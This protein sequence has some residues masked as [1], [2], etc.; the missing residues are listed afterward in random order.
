MLQG[1]QKV[2]KQQADNEQQVALE[3]TP[4]A[5]VLEGRSIWGHFETQSLGNGVSR[6]F[7]EVL[8]FHR[9]HHVVSSEYTQDWPGNNAIKISQVFHDIAWLE[10]FTD[11][12]LFKYVFN[13]I[14][15]WET[16]ALQFYLKVLI[17]LFEVMVESS[18]LRMAIQP[19]V[20][21]S[22][23]PLLTALMLILGLKGLISHLHEDMILLLQPE[24]FRILLSRANQGFFYL[25]NPPGITNLNM[26]GKKKRIVVAVVK[27][28]H[29]A[30]SH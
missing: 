6:G 10:R 20:L 18:Q 8:K 30:M 14:Q 13:V 3:L 5:Q 27:R 25:I 26:K 22:Y 12:N 17:N 9:R 24:S 19:E 21:A 29:H 1:C 7:Q 16:D 4:K 2:F 23:R 11:L 15:N 28:C